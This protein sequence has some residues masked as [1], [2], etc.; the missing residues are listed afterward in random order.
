MKNMLD[1]IKYLIREKLDKSAAQEDFVLENI[2]YV[3]SCHK[4]QVVQCFYVGI[5]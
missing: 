3:P 5:L 4:K 2:N 1:N